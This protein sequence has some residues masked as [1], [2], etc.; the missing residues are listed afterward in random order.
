MKK[1]MAELIVVIG[2]V[3]TQ[4]TNI[5]PASPHFTAVSLWVEPTP[6]ILPAI[7]WV[8]LMGIPN[9]DANMIDKPAE[10]SAEN[11]EIGLSF[12]TL[13]PIVSMTFHPP[14]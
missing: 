2:I 10:V 8:V 12:V 1:S 5:L 14:R 4:A 13:C 3:I 11:P 9:T 6:I 7:V